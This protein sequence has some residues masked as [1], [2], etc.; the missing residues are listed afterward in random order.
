MKNILVR[1]TTLFPTLGFATNYAD[2][3]T[4][5]PP[6]CEPKPCINCESFVPLYQPVEGCDTFVS[7]DA[8]YWFAKEKNL[9]Y[10]IEGEMTPVGESSYFHGS[11]NPIFTPLDQKY[12]FLETGWSPGVRVGIGWSSDCNDWDL[13]VDWTY[14]YNQKASRSSTPPFSA[15]N[16]GLS[17]PFISHVSTPQF[18]PSPGQSAIF[19]P[20]V[21]QSPLW[22]FSPLTSFD[23]LPSASSNAAITCPI[24]FQDVKANWRLTLNDI[25]LTIGRTFWLREGFAFRPYAGVRGAW[26]KTQFQT[27]SRLQE[28]AIF[29]GLAEGSIDLVAKDR[30]I[31]RFWGMGIHLGIEP[32]WYLSSN[33]SIFGDFDASLI[34]GKVRSRKKEN[35]KGS[36][37]GSGSLNATPVFLTLPTSLLD[38]NKTS[39]KSSL[40]SMQPIFDLA[41]GLR[42]EQSWCCDC[43]H[44][45]IDLSWEQH[46]W[47]E[48]KTYSFPST[49]DTQDVWTGNS[50]RQS[51]L[52]EYLMAIDYSTLS[53]TLEYG[54]PILRVRLDF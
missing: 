33:W 46:I 6:C 31:D 34:Y 35:Y 53:T 16:S 3:C 8:L 22:F 14:F 12:K 44:T 39:F 19:N 38:Y 28:T 15:L 45:E 18:F 36:K 21:N 30:F 50:S 20:W 5:P 29:P 11:P 13:G 10:A 51:G 32:N 41:L 40:F 25:A 2:T 17:G 49:G 42:F 4:L 27:K 23:S 54:G 43:Y 37:S 7:V 48:T 9:Y 52:P 1:A 47:L 24:V 26:I